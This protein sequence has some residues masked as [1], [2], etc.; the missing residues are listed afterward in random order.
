MLLVTGDGAYGRVPDGA[1]LRIM[2]IDPGDSHTGWAIIEPDGRVTTGELDYPAVAPAVLGELEKGLDHV[3]VE[4]FVLYPAQAASQRFS[5]FMTARLIGVI[6]YL[7]EQVGTPMTLQG[8]FIKKPMRAQLKARG[9]KQVGSGP[10]E[11]DAE[12]HAYYRRM[13][14]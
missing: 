9:I 13:K 12:L 6:S 4:D 14:G 5:P 11:R 8:A 10:H 2:G 1:P 7:C 3:A